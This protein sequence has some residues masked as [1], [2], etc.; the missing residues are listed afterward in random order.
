MAKPREK[1]NYEIID[2][3]YHAVILT[4]TFIATNNQIYETRNGLTEVIPD[5]VLDRYIEDARFATGIE[6]VDVTAGVS[7]LSVTLGF[8]YITGRVHPHIKRRR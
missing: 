2:E 7:A 3:L 5:D 1:T 6:Q 4:H 8:F